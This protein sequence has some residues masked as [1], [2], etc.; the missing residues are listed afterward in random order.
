MFSY[1]SP[2][3]FPQDIGYISLCYTV[4][5]CCLSILLLLFS[6]YVKLF[7][8][9]WTRA[10]QASLSME[11]SRQAYWSGLPFPSPRNLPDPGTEPGS[12]ALQADSLPSE[13]PGSTQLCGRYALSQVMEWYS[14]LCAAAR[15]ASPKKIQEQPA[16]METRHISVTVQT[17]RIHSTFSTPLYVAS[18]QKRLMNFFYPILM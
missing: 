14:K 7:V 15:G 18:F 3:G 13:P 4:G 5:P 17:V 1:S 6:C 12:P 9:P 11:F 10:L 2:H 8:T 16:L